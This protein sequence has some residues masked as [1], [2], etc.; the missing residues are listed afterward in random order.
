MAKKKKTTKK[1]TSKKPASKKSAKKNDADRFC[2][3]VKMFKLSDIQQAEYNPRVIDASARQGLAKCIERFGLVELPI[4]NVHDGGNV[5]VGGNQRFQIMKSAGARQCLCIVVD[6]SPADE[7]LLNIALNNPAIQGRF[8]DQ[9]DDHID[10][11]LSEISN[12]SDLIDLRITE[13]RSDIARVGSAPE[14]DDDCLPDA[15][16]KAITRPGDLWILGEHRLLC[17]DS[18]KRDDVDVLMGGAKA[19]ICFTSPPYNA[20]K[21]IDFSGKSKTRDNKYVSGHNDDMSGE[22]WLDLIFG[23]WEISNIVSR[24]QFWN[25]QQLASNKVDFITFLNAI[26]N[27]FV[28]MMIWDKGTCP[29]NM[30]KNVLNSR[31]EYVIITSEDENPTREIPIL[32]DRF[33]YV[34]ITSEDENPPKTI[35]TGE[36]RGTIQNVYEGGPQRNNKFSNTHAATFPFHF[37]WYFIRHFTLGKAGVYDAFIGTGTTLLAC[38]ELG[39]RCF[40]MEIDPYYNDIILQR[41]ADYTGKDPT[42]ADGESF[43][44]LKN[45]EDQKLIE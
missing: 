8:S 41:W 27:N 35:K 36:F 42:R 3:K 22:G 1:K 18:T 38:E 25:I 6:F 4:V 43:D 26:K 9:L 5:I 37:P 32:N 12:E 34:V 11:L 44:E 29:P 28:D 31:F 13:L 15:R 24:F 10:Q 17:G 33:E 21:S 39:R 23:A 7:K 16:K 30:A 19:D 2:P 40:G 45:I 20:G 14:I